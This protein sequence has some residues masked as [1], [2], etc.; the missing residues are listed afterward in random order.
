MSSVEEAAGVLAD[1]L[2]QQKL[3]GLFV[4]LIR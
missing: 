3:C 4:R 2:S 1:K